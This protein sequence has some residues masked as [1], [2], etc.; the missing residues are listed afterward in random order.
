VELAVVAMLIL[1]HHT[2][3]PEADLAVAPDRAVV[4][5]RRTDGDSVMAALLKQEPGEQADSLAI[6]S[7][8]VQPQ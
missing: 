3:G 4:G 8:G 1:A 5:R 6:R 2:D 7:V